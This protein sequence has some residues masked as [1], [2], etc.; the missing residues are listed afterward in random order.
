MILTACLF[1]PAAA[2]PQL[3]SGTIVVISYSKQK[4]ILAADSRANLGD[5]R[6]EDSYC[7]VTALS[8]KLIFAATGIVGDN[9][10][11]LPEDLRFGAIE[12]ARKAAASTITNPDP[13]GYGTVGAVA[14]RWG[15]AMTVRFTK[16]SKIRLDEWL[17]A[18]NATD[19]RAFVIGIFAGL[20]PTGEVAVKCV[21]V[22]YGEPQKGHFVPIARYNLQFI[23]M[24]SIP[25][26]ITM[27]EAYGMPEVIQEIKAG[28]TQRAKEEA[29][30]MA[31][32]AKQL[33]PEEFDRARV[34]RLV[35][36]TLAYHPKQKFVGGN[37]DA[38]ELLHSGRVNW[39][40]RK[41]NC[42]AN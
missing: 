1:F 2:R 20:E 24:S 19:E 25:D 31:K 15:Q 23:D 4:V 10:Y 39:I 22:D 13:F 36:L 18:I 40:Q 32:L 5:D 33:T 28:K 38:L 29:V 35:D 16:A 34:I 27:I 41:N 11:L 8:N 26:G 17:K 9:S 3:R 7:K 14:T 12:E 21:H 37:I 30:A 42:P 6:Y